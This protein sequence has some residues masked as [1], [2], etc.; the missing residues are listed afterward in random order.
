MC[1]V[2]FPVPGAVDLLR[3][4]SATPTH[5]TVAWNP[6]QETSGKLVGYQLTVTGNEF[7]G[8]ASRAAR[9]LDLV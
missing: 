4:A 2:L 3:V 6:P 8:I 7:I 9:N 1:F 5:V